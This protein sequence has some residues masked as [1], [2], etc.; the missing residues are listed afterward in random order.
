MPTIGPGSKL[1]SFG[2]ATPALAPIRNCGWPNAAGAAAIAVASSAR[3]TP[4]RTAAPYQSGGYALTP[5]KPD[6]Y[7]APPF[8]SWRL[9]DGEDDPKGAARA[10][11]PPA[12]RP[13]GAALDGGP[14][15]ADRGRG[16]RAAG[17][18]L[19]AFPGEGALRPGAAPRRGRAGTGARPAHPHDRRARPDAPTGRA[20]SAEALRHAERKGRG[21]RRLA[22][23]LSRGVPADAIRRHR[24]A[25]AGAGAVSPR[26]LRRG[27]EDLRR[28][29]RRSPEGRFAARVG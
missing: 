29:P 11:R 17:G 8:V 16:R 27:A 15:E 22:V 25:A 7:I 9:C 21:D 4:F 26:P 12:R 3:R 2:A 14:R 18:R 13:R 10:G 1:S 6:F 19:R 5:P 28:L 20:R 23:A 24:R